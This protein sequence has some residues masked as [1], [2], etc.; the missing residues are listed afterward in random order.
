MQMIIRVKKYDI[1]S[2][3]PT[4][5]SH[6]NKWAV[7][8]ISDFQCSN[9]MNW[10]DSTNSRHTTNTNY[11]FIQHP[12]NG[13]FPRKIQHKIIVQP[14]SF[15]SKAHAE[16]RFESDI[17]TRIDPNEILWQKTSSSVFLFSL[18]NR[19]A[20]RCHPRIRGTLSIIEDWKFVNMNIQGDFCNRQRRIAFILQR[21]SRISQSCAK[22]CWLS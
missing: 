15:D 8:S 3:P 14:F 7:D 13:G 22:V 11:I 19:V 17:K 6:D 9:F 21:I 2:H 10:N 4:N 18:I 12:I 1:P 16:E 20:N 5:S